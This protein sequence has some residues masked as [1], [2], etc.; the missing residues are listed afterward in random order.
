MPEDIDKILKDIEADK[1][2]KQRE[3]EAA[4]KL[5]Q[6]DEQAADRLLEERRNKVSGFKL[7]LDFQ[8]DFGDV[9]HSWSSPQQ[10]VSSEANPEAEPAD[11]GEADALPAQADSQ[12]G[13]SHTRPQAQHMDP[14]DDSKEDDEDE[15]SVGKRS[16]K[17]EKGCLRSIIYAVFVLAISGVLAY[18][19]IVGGLDFIGINKS[20]TKVPVTLTQEQCEDPKLVADV[21]QKAGVIEQP[22]VFRLYCWFKKADGTFQPQNEIAISPNSSYGAIVA[23]LQTTVREVVTVTFPEGSTIAEIAAKLEKNNVCTA[24]DFYNALQAGNYDFD[25]IAEIPTG[26]E[27]DGRFNMLEGYIFPDTYDFY[28]GSSGE[29]VVRKFLNAFDNRVDATRRAAIKA[30][31]MTLNEVLTL[32][33]IIQWEAA[34]A[35]DMYGVSRVI[36]NRLNNPSVFPK[37]ECDST[38]RY[39]DS[40]TPP[41]GGQRVQNKDYDT[42]IRSGLPVGPINNPGLDAIDAAISPSEDSKIIKCYFFATDMKTGITYFR[43]TLAEH[44]AVCRKYGIGMYA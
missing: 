13:E 38:Q 11:N 21:L 4:R 1:Q 33:S 24:T 44:I 19:V 22:L 23:I 2:L 28:V 18:F 10:E 20:E 8:N 37:L 5:L 9:P 43:K 26:K 30:K 40:V 39:V 25:F 16:K 32:A 12:G 34:K 36:H 35:E 29:T 42:Y 31:G 14:T 3:E 6:V 15:D 17:S 27:Y 7:N 41:I